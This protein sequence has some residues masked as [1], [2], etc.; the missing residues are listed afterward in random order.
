VA[1]KGGGMAGI[2]Q[3]GGGDGTDMRGPHVSDR[4][5]RRRFAR[6][7]HLRRENI[8]SG[9]RQGRARAR[10]ADEGDGGLQGRRAS[11]GGLGRLGWIPGEDSKKIRFLNFKDFRN[12]REL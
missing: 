5:E 9:K 7:T 3:R 8:F 4:G 12:L 10:R 2:G 6:E 1:G 11:V